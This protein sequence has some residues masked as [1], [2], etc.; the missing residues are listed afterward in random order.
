MKE[1]T[2]EA[3]MTVVVIVVIGIV[4]SA[5]AIIVPNLM[6]D[7]SNQA[8]KVNNVDIESITNFT[9]RGGAN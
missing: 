2:G 1:A 3:S 6:K 8:S 4:A 5:A 7:V 9:F